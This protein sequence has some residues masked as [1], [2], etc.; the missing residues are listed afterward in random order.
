MGLEGI[1]A[2]EDGETFGIC[3]LG[4][5]EDVGGKMHRCRFRGCQLVGTSCYDGCLVREE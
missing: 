4:S 5:E 1:L 2:V 3:A